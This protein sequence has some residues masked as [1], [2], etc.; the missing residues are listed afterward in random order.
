MESEASLQ[1]WGKG[2]IP[3][4]AQ[5]VKDLVLAQLWHR[6]QLW[7]GSDPWPGNFIC[8]GAA[9]KDK[10]KGNKYIHINV[11]VYILRCIY[12][13][14]SME[15]KYSICKFLS[16]FSFDYELLENEHEGTSRHGS[17]ETNLTS[18]H[19]DAGSI[20]GPAQ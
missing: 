15:I 10:K 5:W 7:L 19:E 14:I 18:I 2:S 3:G 1:H 11:C 13:Y 9:K 4:L 17:V 16:L 20:P 8:H 6:L 12:T